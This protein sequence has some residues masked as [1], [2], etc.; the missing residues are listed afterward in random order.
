ME[1][2]VPGSSVALWGAATEKPS[3]A[4]FFETLFLFLNHFV[5]VLLSF[6]SGILFVSFPPAERSGDDGGA[7]A[8][9]QER[10]G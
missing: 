7:G 1:A 3:T 5:C 8:M 10:Y 2:S 6:T 9:A 4:P